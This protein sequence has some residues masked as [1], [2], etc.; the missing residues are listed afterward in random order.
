MKAGSGFFTLF[1][2]LEVDGPNVVVFLPIPSKWSKDGN[3]LQNLSENSITQLDK[4]SSQIVKLEYPLASRH[5]FKEMEALLTSF[6][7][8]HTSNSSI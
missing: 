2:V 8:P 1:E 3:I 4:M 7:F 5:K 6:L